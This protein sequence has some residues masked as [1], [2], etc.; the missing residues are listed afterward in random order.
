MSN[1]QGLGFAIPSDTIM[2]ELSSLASTG[3]YNQHPTIGITGT[4]M[5]YQIAQAM[6]TSTTYGVLVESVNTQNGLKGGN[7]QVDILG[8]TVTIGGDIIVAI[9]GIRITNSDD[10]LSYLEQH[11]HPGQTASVHCHKKWAITN[12]FH[13]HRNIV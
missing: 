4:D 11:T 7:T 3:S 8:S 5:N 1:S 9:N 2:R 13:N 10:L 6:G 12:N